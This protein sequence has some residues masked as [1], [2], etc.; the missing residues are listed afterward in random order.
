MKSSETDTD[1]KQDEQIRS[2]LKWDEQISTE[3]IKTEN[4]ILKTQVEDAE[5]CD[6]FTS[7]VTVQEKIDML[8]EN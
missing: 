7:D 4:V 6:A 2:D 1:L 8:I 3:D 5:S